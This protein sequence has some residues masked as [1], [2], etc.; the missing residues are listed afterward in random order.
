MKATV[1][2]YVRSDKSCYWQFSKREEIDSN[3][4]SVEDLELFG[5][6]RVK[7]DEYHISDSNCRLIVVKVH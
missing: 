4:I 6:A 3:E 1:E 7:D 5:F 2:T